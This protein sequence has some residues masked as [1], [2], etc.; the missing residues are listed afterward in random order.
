MTTAVDNLEWTK[1][2][3]GL[4]LWPSE[5]ADSE[6]V[7]KWLGV[8]P[9]ITDARALFDASTSATPGMK[10]AEKRTAIEIKIT[11]ERMQAACGMMRWC[12]SHQQL[13]DGVTK[14]AARSKLAMELRR[15]VHCLRYDPEYVASKKVKQEDKDKE[16][17]VLDQA[18]KEIYK[19]HKI[20]ETIF[21]T[22]DMDFEDKA[23]TGIC[24]LEGCGLPT[25]N[26]KRYCTKRH[27]HAAQHKSKMYF[28]FKK[29]EMDYASW[30]A[31]AATGVTG[32]EAVKFSVNGMVI[33]Y[34]Q[35]IAVVIGFFVVILMVFLAGINYGR[36]RALR[37]PPG[38]QPLH[39]PLLVH[40][41]GTRMEFIEGHEMSDASSDEMMDMIRNGG[42]TG[43]MEN[44][45][46]EGEEES[47]LSFEE[48]DFGSDDGL[49]KPATHEGDI[50]SPEHTP[51]LWDGTRVM[52]D[53][54]Q[55][56]TWLTPS[57]ISYMQGEGYYVLSDRE[58]NRRRA[59]LQASMPP[60]IEEVLTPQV[61]ADITAGT[62]DGSAQVPLSAG[63]WNGISPEERE[64]RTK[65]LE[66]CLLLAIDPEDMT[67]QRQ[68]ESIALRARLRTVRTVEQAVA[69]R[70]AG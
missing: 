23:E 13:A 57:Q 64:A 6:H 53:D 12:N 21:K 56:A 49:A 18:A 5:G 1:M 36:R 67:A 55:M 14:A 16:Q 33:P 54:G 39:E 60:S 7:M 28:K 68:Q 11:V 70:H 45:E 29:T 63:E 31:L 40:A 46:E 9:C 35:V 69:E 42:E 27:Y 43:N 37:D 3:F 61:I 34:F 22:E 52:A 10:L 66:D 41:D 15:G 25:E 26:G 32:A 59:A 38:L 24:L 58:V 8:S 48:Q 17:D 30:M 65:M 47:E 50:I 62:Y 4:M 20:Q 2:M 19:K 44:D 51:R